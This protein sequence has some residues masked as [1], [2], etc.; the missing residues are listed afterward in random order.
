MASNGTRG[1]KHL[2][3]KKNIV[4][5]LLYCL[6]L[7]FFVYQGLVNDFSTDMLLEYKDHFFSMK[8]K[9]QLLFSFLFVLSYSL[10]VAS[11][12]SITAVLNL[13]AG[14]LFGTTT[15]ALLACVG[16]TAGSYILFWFIRFTVKGF[17]WDLPDLHYFSADPGR[18]FFILFFMRMSPLLPASLVTAG[19]A[20]VRLKDFIFIPA[21]FL[22]LFPLILVYAMIGGQ[23]GTIHH[24]HDIYNSDLVWLLLLLAG[25]SCLPLVKKEVREMMNFSKIINSIKR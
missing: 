11:S 14:Y 9:H 25:L 19:F 20:L 24:V 13:L 15:G 3:K 16:G 6:P 1:G 21:T 2:S 10:F 8:N 23:L 5:V 22:G 7:L 17:R 4:L 18:G 12:I